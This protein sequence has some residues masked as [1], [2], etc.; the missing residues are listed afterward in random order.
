MVFISKANHKQS[1]RGESIDKAASHL[2]RALNFY[3]AKK[4]EDI[5]ASL[6]GIGGAYEILGHLSHKDIPA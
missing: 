5:D 4:Q 6:V 2:E 3:A 1:T